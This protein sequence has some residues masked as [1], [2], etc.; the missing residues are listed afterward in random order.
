MNIT[1]Y[2]TKT[3]AHYLQ[4]TL[5]NAYSWSGTGKG[6]VNPYNFQMTIP[7]NSRWFGVNR[8]NYAYI[9]EWG[10]YYWVEAEHVGEYV[11]LTLSCDSLA[12]G[13]ADIRASRGH[14][15]RS[16]SN[17]DAYIS[18]P[19][20]TVKPVTRIVTRKIGAGWAT[21]DHYILTIGGK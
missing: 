12:T 10:I 1:F 16:A 2:K 7:Y 3:P 5:E 6:N 11:V 20:V 9:S 14:I 21:G 18:D 4:K 8:L 15:V 19:M 17:G 13:R